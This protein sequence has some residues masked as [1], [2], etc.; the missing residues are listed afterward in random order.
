MKGKGRSRLRIDHWSQ[1]SKVIDDLEEKSL[2]GVG[3]GEKGRRE[4]TQ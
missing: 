2:F 1:P 3:L 4:F